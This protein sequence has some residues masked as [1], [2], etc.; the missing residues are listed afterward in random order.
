[1]HARGGKER[2]RETGTERE[3]GWR[4]YAWRWNKRGGAGE[5]AAVAA[6]GAAG[7][8]PPGPA[9][10]PQ[11]PLL[12]SVWFVSLQVD[13]SPSPF[14]PPS[15][16]L[17]LSPS[18]ASSPLPPTPPPPT[19]PGRDSLCRYLRLSSPVERTPPLNGMNAE[20]KR[21]GW[22]RRPSTSPSTLLTWNKI[23]VVS[24]KTQGDFTLAT[25]AQVPRFRI[26]FSF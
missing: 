26:S 15:L 9:G 12:V 13:V 22:G 11:H 6:C 4:W 2:Q 10:A 19:L 8:G 5:R 3:V 14:F 23:R 16:P 25:E 20:C 21:C 24:T 7:C 1:M 17:S 18:L